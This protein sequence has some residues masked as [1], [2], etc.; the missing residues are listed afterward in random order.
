M[1]IIILQ[2]SLKK[3]LNLTER[4][5]GRNLTLPILNNLLLTT[6][7]NRLKISA[8][9]LEIALNIWISA[10]IEKEGSLTIPAKLLNSFV[11]Q[12]PNQKLV[13]ENQGNSLSIKTEGHSSIINGVD[14]KD[15]PLIPKIKTTDFFELENLIFKNSLLQVLNS[16]SVS[17]IRPEISSI[18]FNFSATPKLVSTDGFRL[19]EKTLEGLFKK[20]MQSFILP[21]KAAQELTRIF[22]LSE[23]KKTKIFS[24]ANQ[25]LFDL[26]NIH[27]ISRLIEGDYPNYEPIIPKSYQTRLILN[28]EE[29]LNKIRITSVFSSKINDIKLKTNLNENKLEILAK[30]EFGE[31][32]SELKV[33]GEGDDLEISFNYK[34][35]LDGLTNI[36]G[37]EVIL[38]FQGSLNPSLL[39]SKTDHNYLYVV[40]PLRTT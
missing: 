23:E 15:F 6:D 33:Q 17:E 18:L 34:Y 13:L 30:S 21:L 32:Q 37:E 2:E 5:I 16:A 7:K 26:G 39:K 1:K 8:T 9:D 27:L 14:A 28:K 12:L 10:K 20:G 40:M 38:E 36:I 19:A 29:L 3:Y 24:E 35:F 31:N 4:I 22:D 25:V 11:N